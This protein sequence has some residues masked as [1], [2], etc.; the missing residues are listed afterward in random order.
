MHCPMLLPQVKPVNYTG[1]F[2]SSD[3][4]LERAWYTGAY[5]SRLNMMPHV[6]YRDYGA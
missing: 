2:S 4:V 6:T 1:S 3:D 5:G